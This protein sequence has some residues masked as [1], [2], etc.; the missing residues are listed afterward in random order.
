MISEKSV[1]EDHVSGLDKKPPERPLLETQLEPYAMQ[2]K[3][4]VFPHE[5]GQSS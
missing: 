4:L 1:C 3:Q 5:L 2:Q